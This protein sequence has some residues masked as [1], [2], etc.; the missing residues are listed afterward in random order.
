MYFAEACLENSLINSSENPV[1]YHVNVEMKVIKRNENDTELSWTRLL[2][3]YYVQSE[4]NIFE[5]MKGKRKL[6]RQP[7]AKKLRLV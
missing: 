3:P 2:S 1:I 7:K 4:N 5:K 6:N